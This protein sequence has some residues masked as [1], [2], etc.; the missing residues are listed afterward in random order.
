[1]LTTQI[2]DN[3]P[4]YQAADYKTIQRGQQYFRDGRVFDIDYHQDFAVCQVEG[5]N[6]TY[7]VSISLTGKH[8][9]QMGCT[10]PQAEVTKVCKHMVA[11]LLGLSQ[12]LRSEKMQSDWQY[13]LALALN[14]APRR[15]S[16]R[17]QRQ[18]AMFLLQKNEYF[19][20][21]SFSLAARTLSA[22]HWDV[23]KAMEPDLAAINQAL[24]KDRS[25]TRFLEIPYRPVNPEG[26]VNLPP[27]G[28][29]FFNLAISY[30]SYYGFSNFHNYFHMLARMEVPIFL[31]DRNGVVHARVR[32]LTQPVEIR[33]ALARTR[34]QL[35][36]QAGIELDGQL[37]TSAKKNLYL[38][39]NNPP[40]ALIGNTIVPVANP[41]SLDILQLFPLTIPAAQEEIFRAK[42]FRLIAERVPIQGD[43][44]SWVDIHEDVIPRLYIQNN[45][46]KLLA[47]LRFGYGDFETTAAR[48][49]APVFMVDT[50]GS[51]TL[52][53][54]HRQPGRE[55]EYFQLL[56]D[57]RFGLKRSGS[58]FQYG[59]FEMRA[60]TH[61][62]D[63][64]TR[65]IPM[66]TAAGFE[67]YGDRDALGRVSP[68]TPTI[69][70]NITSGIDW[71]ELNAVVQYGDQQVKLC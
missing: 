16:S 35:T 30:G 66:L 71:F 9:I 59:S 1:M 43:E 38:L 51:W 21:A 54:V 4:Y 34:D 53:R 50:P 69:R 11:A 15:S 23:L 44:V 12:Y 61:P 67:I 14:N 5:Q 42:Y 48:N 45:E 33:A 27:E 41:E 17:P 20:G 19:Q 25:W 3:F 7:E 52:T 18:V 6:G 46:G 29:S 37:F 63:F 28:V 49:P 2:I 10:C 57:P 60:R 13:R 47:E 70:L 62:F 26:V 40:W 56:A 31:A 22:A 32:I 39:S 64:L 58:A 65:S 8:N 36:L 68:H 24:D 55:F